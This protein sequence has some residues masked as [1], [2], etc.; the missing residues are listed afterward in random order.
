VTETLE[1]PTEELTRGTTFANRFEI[2]EELGKGGM[3]KVYR[4]ED[5]KIKE[6]VAL[7]LIKP[8]IASDKKTIER[9]SNELK[10]T[11]KIAHRNVCKMYDLGEEKGTHYITMEYV[12]GEDLKGSIR[13]MGPLTAG[14]TLFIAKQVCEGLA[15]AHRLGVI[16]R[17]LKPQNIMIDKD[18]N[19]RIMDFGI[20]RSVT[21]K[22]I[23]GAGVMVGT[24]EYM[25]P[26][27]VEVKE[28]DQRSDIYSLGVILYEMVTGRVP[29][30]GETPLGIAMKHK[31]EMPKDP[32]ELNAQIPEDL[33]RVIL[34]CMEKDKEKR[35]QN[36][37]EVHSELINIE[38]GIPTTEREVPKRKPITSREITV[39]FGL[40]K[41]FIPALVVIALIIAAVVIWKPLLRKEAIPPAPSGKPSLAVMYFKNN[42]GDD[43]LDHWRTALSDLLIADLTQSKY[44]RVISGDR[45]FNILG[46][47]DLLEAI[48]YSSEDLRK[49]ASRGRA[50]HILQGNLTKAGENFRINITL[51]EAATGELIGSES[52]DGKGEESIISMV[53]E[54][55]TRIK[56]GFKLSAEQIAGDIDKNVGEITTSSPEALKYYVEGL[57]YFNK[58]ELRK[59]LQSFEKAVSIDP[60]FALAYR[61]MAVANMG[62][63]YGAK[64]QEYMKK[65]FELTGR[66]SERERYQI[67]GTFYLNSEK[68]YDKAIEAYNKLL[69]LY[70]DDVVGNSNLGTIYARIEE[71]DKAIE[72]TGVDVKNRVEGFISYHNLASY[73]AAKGMYDKAKE[74][75]E[76]YLNDFSDH[77]FIRGRLALNYLAQG[78]YD[79]A[80][81]EVD[82]AISLDPTFYG[83]FRAKGD[84]YLIQGDL[85]KAKKEYQKLF[86]LEE[87]TAHLGGKNRLIA[88]NLARGKFAEA[89]KEAIEGIKLAEELGEKVWK[90]GFHLILGYTHLSSGQPENALEECDKVLSEALKSESFGGQRNSLH[91]KG[92]ILLEMS[93][94]DEAQ[95]EANELKELIE[96]GLNRKEIRY[97]DHLTGRI[98]LE[99]ENFSIAIKNFE[100]ALSLIPNQSGAASHHALFIEA[101]ALAYY[102]SGDLEKAEEQYKKIISLTSGR[103]GYGNIYAKSFYM[104]GKIYEQKG[105]KG[106]AIEHYDRFLELWKDAD[107]GIPEF[108][109]AKKRLAGLK[110][111]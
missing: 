88:L 94:L 48:S 107:P 67:E 75:L 64:R 56:A 52:V 102:R 25:S 60:E 100:K 42:T 51:Q 46:Q 71:W 38:K 45:L 98:Q 83:Y 76:L 63:G 95:R 70:P 17:D 50:N 69:E 7:K 44:I 77:A 30:E 91:L 73:Y 84:I 15:E 104:L 21:G 111:K 74:V 62:L 2:I 31:S 97:Y 36:P 79:L 18:G 81:Q 12:P 106:K 5:K 89:K 85:V 26:E 53:D 58:A 87:K 35:Y 9:F 14:K 10:M 40:K 28:V 92:S 109:D 24:P 11:R 61:K 3:G 68:T 16:H 49:V 54:L 105:W 59:S 80:H 47:L 22:G 20:A 29:F 66:V 6:E 108:E 57:K 86:E 65:A 32:R 43:D 1:T 103:L 110:I 101:L 55:T 27:Q 34:R 39:T 41:L 78:K 93:A 19:A 8:E 4:V 13:R 37:G 23:T 82:R 90:A 96:K 33:S 99:L 72:H